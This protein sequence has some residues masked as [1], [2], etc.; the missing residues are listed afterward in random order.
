[1][2]RWELLVSLCVFTR[3][4]RPQLRTVELTV[5]FVLEVERTKPL[6]DDYSATPAGKNIALEISDFALRIYVVNFNECA[7]Y[8]GFR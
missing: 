6:D 1:M 3:R 7:Q 2:Q 8:T 5:G 4:E